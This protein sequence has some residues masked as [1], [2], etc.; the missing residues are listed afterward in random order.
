MKARGNEGGETER[1]GRNGSEAIRDRSQATIGAGAARR[2]SGDWEIP[3]ADCCFAEPTLTAIAPGA[4][5]EMIVWIYFSGETTRVFA[6]PE[7]AQVW[8]DQNDPEGV[9]FEYEVEGAEYGDETPID[10]ERG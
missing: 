3:Y 5:G 1:T 7:V 8:F 9:A 6:I 10:L 2:P 4:E